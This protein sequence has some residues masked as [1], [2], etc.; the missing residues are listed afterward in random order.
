MSIEENKASVR[1]EIEECWHSGNLRIVDEIYAVNFVNYNP[2][3]GTTPDREGI[4]EF[5]KNMRIAFPDIRLTIED[6]IAE[7]DKVVEMVT[8]TGTNK[9]EAMGIAP[10]GKRIT[11][12]VITINRFIGSKIAERWSISDQLDIMRQ[13][14]VLPSQ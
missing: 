14:G 4:K 2:F 5:I 7:N 3:P 10:T 11:F 9:G 13:L 1:R 8:I 12:P 6:L